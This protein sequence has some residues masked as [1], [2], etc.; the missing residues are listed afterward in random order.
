MPGRSGGADAGTCDRLLFLGPAQ[1][2]LVCPLAPTGGDALMAEARD[3]LMV[4]TLE[5]HPKAGLAIKLLGHI[6]SNG[7]LYTMKSCGI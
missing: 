3:H 1:P 7:P 2:P 4:K 6:P 5:T